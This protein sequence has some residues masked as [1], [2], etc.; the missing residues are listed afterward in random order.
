MLHLVFDCS[1]LMPLGDKPEKEKKAIE[2]IGEL[3][4]P[5]PFPSIFY[6]SGHLIKV[7]QSKVFP[8]LKKLSPL[9]KFQATLIR[10]AP[11]LKVIKTKRFLCRIRRTLQANFQIHLL[12]AGTISK[13]NVKELG[14]SEAE[15]EE[16][17]KVALAASFEKTFLIAAD[18]HFLEDL[19]LEELRKRYPERGRKLRIVKPSEF[20]EE[21]LLMEAR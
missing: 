21:L 11:W 20:L 6:F 15:D 17:L 9:P 5:P 16:V 8:E 7:Y 19:N 18:R 4:Y 14:L 10:L 13:Y 1:A 12:E 3:V 2:K